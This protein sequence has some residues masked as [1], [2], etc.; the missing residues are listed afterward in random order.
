M[1]G[2]ELNNAIVP[3][4]Q[5]LYGGPLKDGIPALDDPKFEKGKETALGFER[6]VL[7]IAINNVAKAYPLSILNYHEV[8]NDYFGDKGIVV[9]YC[10]LCGSGVAFKTKIAG[11]NLS[12]GVSGLLYNSDVL[13]YDRQTHSLWSQLMS[14]AISG[15]YVGR[16]METVPVFHGTWGTWLKKHPN[17]LVLS[18]QT[19][20]QR[21]YST[22]PYLGYEQSKSIYFPVSHADSSYHP[23]EKILGVSINGVHK[24]YPFSELKKVNSPELRDTIRGEPI[25]ILFDIESNSAELIYN[26]KL[27]HQSVTLFWFAWIAFHPNTAVYT[28]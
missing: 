26:G 21:D 24:A 8:V 3:I 20:F 12:F 1:N 23:K 2:F 6:E 27:D 25:S 10:P 17:T 4:D 18:K 13:L 11:E 9:T 19:G 7:G 14:K 28:E 22:T 16:T 5:I 15:Q